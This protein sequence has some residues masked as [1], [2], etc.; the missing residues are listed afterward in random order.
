MD[1]RTLRL[2]ERMKKA[3]ADG[4]EANEAVVALA[5]LLADAR[6]ETVDHG[7]LVKHATEIEIAAQRVCKAVAAWR[8]HY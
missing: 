3:E 4:R 8:Q 6:P 5:R 7:F 2:T 1:A